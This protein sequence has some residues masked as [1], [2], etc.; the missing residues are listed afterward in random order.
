M[1]CARGVTDT[2]HVRS[3]YSVVDFIDILVLRKYT[4][5]RGIYVF[6]RHYALFFCVFE[7]DLNHVNIA[8]LQ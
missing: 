3:E 4:V 8:G 2:W 1:R 5:C 7:I 6:V